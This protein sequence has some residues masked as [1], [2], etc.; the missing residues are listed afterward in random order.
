MKSLNNAQQ[1]PY[2]KDASRSIFAFHSI[3][4]EV[5]I[6]TYCSALAF[7]P[8]TNELKNRFWSH[9]QHW[10]KDIR[11]A[12]ALAAKVKDEYNYVNNIA[13]TPDGRQVAS[14]TTSETAK[15]WDVASKA[16]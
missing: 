11:N 10:M 14:G 16:T 2:C 9:I 6:Q 15:L 5:P 8:P 7:I 4:G 1:E 3:L 13:F 12:E